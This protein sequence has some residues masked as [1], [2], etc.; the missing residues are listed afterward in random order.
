MTAPH[1][2]TVKLGELRVGGTFG[3]TP[4]YVRITWQDCGDDPSIEFVAEG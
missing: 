3:E 1:E 2:L 4:G